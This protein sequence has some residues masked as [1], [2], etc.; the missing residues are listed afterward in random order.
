MRS[1]PLRAQRLVESTIPRA[2]SRTLAAE[3]SIPVAQIGARQPTRR[4]PKPDCLFS[5]GSASSRLR[6][7]SILNID[8]NDCAKPLQ[9]RSEV[10]SN[11]C[12]N[13]G[14]TRSFRR[15]VFRIAVRKGNR[16]VVP[17]HFG[18][19]PTSRLTYKADV[20]VPPIL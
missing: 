18:A 11:K 3:G 6:P 9:T 8:P 10:K 12:P 17:L 7:R 19:R 20:P 1:W 16:F 14:E 15:S 5:D 2:A 13:R 4:H